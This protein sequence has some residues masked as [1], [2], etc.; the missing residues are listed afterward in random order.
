MVQES[1][2]EI[3][4]KTGVLYLGGTSI[5]ITFPLSNKADLNETI[6]KHKDDI[7]EL[8]IMNARYQIFGKSLMCFGLD[9]IWDRLLLLLIKRN[10][11]E[12]II[13]HPCLNNDL[14]FNK[15]LDSLT[16]K[17]CL[18]PAV[19]LSSNKFE[20]LNYQFNGKFNSDKCYEI[21]NSL[22]DH[23]ECSKEFM[24]CANST[25]LAPSR[26]LTF[27]A[28]YKLYQLTRIFGKNIVNIS[29]KK[30]V[31]GMNNWCANELTTVLDRDIMIF[32]NA[33]QYCFGLHY[34]ESMLINVF[35]IAKE[36]FDHINFIDRLDKQQIDWSLGYLIGNLD[37]KAKPTLSTYFSKL[38]NIFLLLLSFTPIFIF[39][40]F[41]KEIRDFF[42]VIK[43][44]FFRCN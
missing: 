17:L 20:H 23:E 25:L 43:F 18:R 2:I 44:K 6:E 42:N 33:I 14:K 21:V 1:A 34:I 35:Q 28:T 13:D 10:S 40:S 30:F 5:R 24:F 16:S 22:I 41:K 7:D 12:Q 9:Q 31:E 11:N 37:L 36:D 39:Y 8:S 19:N 29:H 26:N 3:V 15:T 27:I 32:K 38:G 4:R